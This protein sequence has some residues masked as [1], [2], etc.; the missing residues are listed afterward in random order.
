[1]ANQPIQMVVV[2]LCFMMVLSGS[3]QILLMIR[4]EVG[5]V[6]EVMILVIAFIEQVLSSKI[7]EV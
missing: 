6:M 7:K 4:A 2:G 1:M 3:S 5:L